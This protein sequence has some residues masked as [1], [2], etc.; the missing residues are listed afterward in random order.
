MDNIKAAR[1]WFR[2]GYRP[3]QSSITLSKLTALGENWP[4]MCLNCLGRVVI[5]GR[6]EGINRANGST[7]LGLTRQGL[8]P[9]SCGCVR[10]V[11]RFK[12]QRKFHVHVIGEDSRGGT[13]IL[14]GN[15]KHD[16]D[17]HVHILSR[18]DELKKTRV[19]VDM[20]STRAHSSIGTVTA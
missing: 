13:R 16:V 4:S 19:R 20:D 18:I 1:G 3:P 8:K 6:I 5:P 7:L 17:N 14:F 2:L 12:S 15:E 10:D 11:E 9:T